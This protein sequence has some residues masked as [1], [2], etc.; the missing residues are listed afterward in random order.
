MRNCVLPFAFLALL[1][2]AAC[3]KEAI[4]EYDCTG[5]TPTYTNDVQPILENSCAII[6]CHNFG[7]AQG[8][9]SFADYAGTKAANN[10]NRLLGA[11]QHKSGYRAMPE[12]GPQLPDSSIKLISCWVQNGMPQ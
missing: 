9:I 3:K 5:I 8:G 12:G 6:G 2:L 7:S 10:K 11:I 1:S 4:T